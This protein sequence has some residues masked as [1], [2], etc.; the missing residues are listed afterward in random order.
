M[1]K[2]RQR[3]SAFALMGLLLSLTGTSLL[4]QV[5]TATISGTVSD[6]SGASVPD[7]VV[8]VKNTGTGITQS[9]N[10]DGQ[11]RFT[12]PSLAVGE[13][14][15]TASKAGFQTVV[16]DRI[17]LTVG[18]SVVVDFSMPVGQSQQTVTVEGQVSQVETTSSA[19]S[20]LVDQKQI[21][22]IPLNGRN[23]QQLILLS[24]GVNVAQ[25]ATT[26]FYGKGDTYSIAGGRPEGQAFLLDGTDIVNFFGHGSGAGSLGTSL[27]IDAIAEFQTLTNTYS[28]Q[29][30]G[31]GAVVN[32]VSKS[33]TNAFHGT[34]FEFLRNSDLDARDFFTTLSHSPPPF[35]RNQFGGAVG[36]P[37]KKDKLFFFFNYEGLRQSLGVENKVTVPNAAAHQGFIT[38]ADGSTTF[39]GF[40]TPLLQQIMNLYP[41]A[42]LTPIPGSSLANAFSDGTQTGNE[43][44]LLG[45]VDYNLNAKDSLFAR[46]VLDKSSFINPF[47]ASTISTWDDSEP[48]RN[49]YLTA[50][51]KHIVSPTVINVARGSYVRTENSAKT[52]GET[53]ALQFYPH[54]GGEDGTVSVTGLSLLGPSTLAPYSLIQNKYGLS[55]DI[56][57]T[58]GAHNIKFGLGMQRLQTF[59]NQPFS[60][61]GAFTF[62]SLTTFMQGTPNRYGGAYPIGV[63]NPFSGNINPDAYRAFR[64]TLIMPYINDDWKV[65]SKLTLNIGLRYDF[66]TN[67]KSAMNNLLVIPNPPFN[68]IGGGLSPT[69]YLQQE[70]NVWRHNPSLNNWGPR[71]GFAYDV[72][73]DHKTS[74]RAGFGDTHNVIAPRTYTS[75]YVTGAPFP[76]VIITPTVQTPVIAFPNPFAGTFTQPPYSNGQAVDYNNTKTPALYQWNANIQHEFPGSWLLTVGYVGSHGSHLFTG[77]D[78]N[79]PL[80][81]TDAN[82]VL[83]FGTVNSAGVGVSNPRWNPALGVI[84]ALQTNGRSSYN[85]LQTNAVHRF[86]RNF[87]AQVNYTWAHSIDDGSASSGL[88]TGGGGRSNPY[89]FASE[90]GDSTFDIRHAVRINGVYTLPFKGNKFVEG[91]QISGIM[92][93]TT[94]PPIIIT[95]GIDQ[96]LTGQAG[97]QRPNFAPGVTAGSIETGTVN[98]WYNPL[99]YTL[100]PIGTEGNAGRDIIRGPGVFN[101]DASVLKDTRIPKISEQ[102]TIQFRAEFFNFLNH[103]NFGIPNLSL[104]TSS[105]GAR[106]AAA[107][108]IVSS[109]PGTIPRE[110]Q[111]AVKLIF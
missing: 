62:A 28:A 31:N 25:T 19:V 76:S 38:N 68:S 64:E 9:T 45:R 65:T 13:Y 7:A 8:Q 66:D 75:G 61:S 100:Q 16:R 52:L 27:G 21:A 5:T 82:G 93:K 71:V 104:F 59:E 18:G 4:A 36:G 50:E 1:T 96:A 92:S 57:M 41:I 106:N 12:V 78:E 29:F 49:Q 63:P 11:G 24:P 95:T 94:G 55:D 44:Y 108:Q 90:R 20:N 23:F 79:P 103:E 80:V 69:N 48:T 98:E 35:R 102:F 14:Q 34:G 107:G 58:R 54:Q 87:Q 109:N 2:V 17:T 22:D 60:A 77:S 88:E 101:M 37:I 72:F 70:P 73:K 86:S 89:D 74:F 51:F 85:S 42:G 10:T 84:N 26:S 83:H 99:G 97:N 33:G 105:S 53:P 30:G 67:P 15:V 81:T 91:W 47:P 39:I 32:A 6:S 56:Y 3:L 46:Y 43:N 40:K 111:F 110:I